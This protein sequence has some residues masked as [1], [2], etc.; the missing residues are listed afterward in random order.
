MGDAVQ[1]KMERPFRASLVAL[2]R[3]SLEMPF[4]AGFELPLR[5]ELKILGKAARGKIGDKR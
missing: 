2:L 4:R 1:G 5:P 3:A